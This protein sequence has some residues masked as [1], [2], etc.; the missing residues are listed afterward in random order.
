MPLAMAAWWA[1]KEHERYLDAPGPVAIVSAAGV[2]EAIPSH[3]LRGTDSLREL[4]PL[5]TGSGGRFR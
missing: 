3:P 1:W 4:A 2:L 5:L